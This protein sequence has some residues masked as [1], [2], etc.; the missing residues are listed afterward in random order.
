M[1]LKEVKFLVDEMVKER[2]STLSLIETIALIEILNL[3]GKGKF[4]FAKDHVANLDKLEA[5]FLNHPECNHPETISN[6]KEI[7]NIELMKIVDQLVSEWFDL[8]DIFN[9]LDSEFSCVMD[10]QRG[11][12]ESEVREERRSFW[13]PKSITRGV[14]KDQVQYMKS[15]F[16][17]DSFDN[18]LRLLAKRKNKILGTEYVYYCLISG[19]IYFEYL[20]FK[21]EMQE[22]TNKLKYFLIKWVG[23]IS[24]VFFFP[25]VGSFLALLT[26]IYD[27][28]DWKGVF[29]NYRLFA[30]MDKVNT[31]MQ[32]P[33]IS[34]SELS[35]ELQKSKQEGVVWPSPLFALVEE[36]NLNHGPV[37]NSTQ[38]AGMHFPK[39]QK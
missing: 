3:Y 19:Y 28:F 26:L 34:V 21:S 27:I 29:R 10:K 9:E 38:P 31:F 30:A 36:F 13:H 14:G 4:E 23:L 37:I 1:Y 8:T 6:F 22:S 15:R 2:D 35:M 16:T 20:Y 5:E 11:I 25:K 32:S 18:V 39:V 24:I 33:K 7:Q 17:K 12:A